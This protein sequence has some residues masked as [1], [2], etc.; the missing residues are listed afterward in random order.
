MRQG[1]HCFIFISMITGLLFITA[2]VSMNFLQA[3]ALSQSQ[4]ITTVCNGEESSCKTVTCLEGRTCYTYQ[5]LPSH[6]TTQ[7]SSHPTVVQQP[8][9][10]DSQYLQP[11][12]DYSNSQPQDGQA[13]T[14]LAD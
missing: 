8:V 1:R 6:V 3:G 10:G 14:T 11:M 13:G 4:T 9:S 7:E 2:Y 5:S 12:E